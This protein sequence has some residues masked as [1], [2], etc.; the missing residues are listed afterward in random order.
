MARRKTK[1]TIKPKK[2]LYDVA[3]DK[4]FWVHNGPI[5]K[6]LRELPDALKNMSD[7]IF[8]HHV[9]KQKN[10]FSTWIRDVVGDRELAAS[11]KRIRSRTGVIKKVKERLK[12][13]K[14]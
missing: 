1:D 6:N 12:Q 7:E 2:I 3:P 5:I 8:K 13:V 9:N 4:C 10:D 11:L 14:K